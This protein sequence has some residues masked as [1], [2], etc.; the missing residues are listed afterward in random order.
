MNQ[1]DQN[2]LH[3]NG[4]VFGQNI[5]KIANRSTLAVAHVWGGGASIGLL[6]GRGCDCVRRGGGCLGVKEN[7]F[8]INPAL[9]DFKGL[10]NCIGHKRP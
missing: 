4:K 7:K 1:I 10:T 6:I 3:F 5:F 2:H 9:T 8:Q